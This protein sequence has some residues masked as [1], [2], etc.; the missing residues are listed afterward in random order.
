M[1]SKSV[2]L[3]VCS[4]CF[5]WSLCVYEW[6]VVPVVPSKP[7]KPTSIKRPAAAAAAAPVT[8]LPVLHSSG[9]KLQHLCSD[10]PRRIKSTALTRPVVG[11]MLVG[12]TIDEEPTENDADTRMTRETSLPETNI[13]NGELDKG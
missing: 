10:R 5:Q 12:D 8:G 9:P 2:I 13:V 11:M 7:Q 3:C 4:G 1:L 6:L